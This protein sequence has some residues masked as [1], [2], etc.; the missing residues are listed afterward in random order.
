[1]IINKGRGLFIR[2]QGPAC[3]IRDNGLILGN[4]RGFLT[5]LHVKGY[6]AL[7]AIGS[8]INDREQIRGERADAGAGAP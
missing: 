5:K 4:P 3:E 7:S 1:V 6:R 2:K 8:E